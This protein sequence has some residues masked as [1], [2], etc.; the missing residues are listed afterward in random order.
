VLLMVLVV[1]CLGFAPATPLTAPAAAVGLHSLTPM[2]LLLAVVPA[3][4]AIFTAYDGWYA[5]IYTAEENADAARTL[6]RAIIGGALLVSV[7]YLIINAAF[8]RVLPLPVLAASALPAAD[9]AQVVLPRGGVQ[10]VT[11]ISVLTV[12]SLI[13]TN[14]LVAPR[15]LFA[16]AR[17]GWIPRRAAAVTGGGTP[18]VALAASMLAAALMIL[19]ASFNQII[20]FFAVLIMLYYVSAFLAIFVLR[21]RMPAAS[22]PYRAFGYPFS[23]AVVLLGS[24]AFLVAAVIDDW[25][26]AVTAA[27]FVAAC[28]PVYAWAARSRRAR[29]GLELP[30]PAGAGPAA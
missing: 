29:L 23:T 1:G 26:S 17:D 20:A 24:I 19:T 9:A 27:V 11:V 16:L 18:H 14:A 6:P 10:L 22:R 2:A 21:Y 30:A 7:L 3:M 8:L 25:R 5:P 13:N 28:V 4:R 15:V 12:L